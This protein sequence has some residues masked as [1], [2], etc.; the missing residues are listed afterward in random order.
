MKKRLIAYL[1]C[2]CMMFTAGCG[3]SDA[4]DTSA[5][6]S[7]DASADASTERP[8][9]SAL[10]YVTLG[11]YTGLEITS[12]RYTATENEYEETLLSV[13]EANAEMVQS[14]KTTVEDGDTINLDYVGAIDGVEFDG[15]SDEGYD[16]EIGSDTF[17]DDFED[18]LIGVTVGE[19]VEVNV[20]FPDDY[21]SE[22]LA[23]QDAVFT[24]VVNYIY[25]ESVPEYTDDFV[26]E[27]TDGEYTTTE[28]FDEYIWDYL[29]SEAASDTET[30]LQSN[31][32]EAIYEV[33]E[34]TGIPDGLVDY[35]VEFYTAQDEEYAEYYGMDLETFVV[36]YYGYDD[37]DAY[38]EDLA[39]YVTEDM[40]PY[41]LIYE[42]IAEQE[43]LDGD[44]A[45]DDLM[46]YFAEV[47][48]FDDAD[49][50]LDY[51]GYLTVAD[52]ISDYGE[53]NFNILCVQFMVLEF[54]EASAVITYVDDAGTDTAEE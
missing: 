24:C 21:S 38:L 35:Y 32:Q 44:E 39:T 40:L 10:D 47:Y 54:V 26:N 11:D 37:L 14:D 28:E 4:D 36:A 34:T 50:F 33:C 1:L 5:D 29:E 41:L 19:T 31:L 13:L 9:Y 12:T 17:I 49:S 20:T 8:D 3:N 51:Y 46:A 27:L 22:D 2:A 16:L 7:S 30:E 48:G 52:F 25:E 53:E 43:G 6:A 23:G 18:Q 15:G 42:A 45:V